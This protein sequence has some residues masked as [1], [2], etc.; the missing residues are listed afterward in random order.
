M[1]SSHPLLDAV[2]LLIIGGVESNP[3]PAPDEDCLEGTPPTAESVA[4]APAADAH[5]DMPP[6]LSMLSL[7][8]RLL[9]SV[10]RRSSSQPKWPTAFGANRLKESI[11]NGHWETDSD[12][13]SG[14]LA[15]RFGMERVYHCVSNRLVS[16]FAWLWIFE[17]TTAGAN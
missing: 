3:G 11:S 16:L 5:P 17:Y 4:V 12:S 1:S 7:E 9:D 8:V 2:K 6:L 14:S 10:S 13:R 15:S